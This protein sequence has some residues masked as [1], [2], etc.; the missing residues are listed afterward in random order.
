MIN[1]RRFFYGVRWK[2]TSV[3]GHN[4]DFRLVKK[5]SMQFLNSKSFELV[6]QVSDFFNIKVNNNDQYEQNV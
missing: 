5:R 3:H 2:K 4:P 1:L 6:I